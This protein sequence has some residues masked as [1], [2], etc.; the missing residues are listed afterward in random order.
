MKTGHSVEK[1]IVG[2]VSDTAHAH[3]AAV[4]AEMRDLGAK[5]LAVAETA[6]GLTA[7]YTVELASGLDEITRAPL[8]LPIL[9]LLAY[10]RALTN[11]MDPDRPTNLEQVIRLE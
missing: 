11:G 6:H 9:Q 10:Y 1:L 4:L 8:T 2:L 3:E 5:V 7:D